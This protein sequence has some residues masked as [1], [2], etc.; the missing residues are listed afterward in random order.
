MKYQE[1]IF[2]RKG[3]HCS[4]SKGLGLSDFKLTFLSAMKLTNLSIIISITIL[5][6]RMNWYHFGC[7]ESKTK[8]SCELFDSLVRSSI[9]HAKFYANFF[10]LSII[11]SFELITLQFS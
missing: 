5:H 8:E 2:H 4:G 1:L 3:H 6:E 7:S 10:S 9:I 11:K